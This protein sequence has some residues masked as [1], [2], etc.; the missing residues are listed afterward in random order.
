MNF[1]L[2]RGAGLARFQTL[3]VFLGGRHS[4]EDISAPGSCRAGALARRLALRNPSI[5]A[6]SFFNSS[7]TLGEVRASS[8]FLVG[9]R[10]ARTPVLHFWIECFWQISHFS[11]FPESGKDLRAKSL[12]NLPLICFLPHR[13][14]ITA[15]PICS[16]LRLRNY[17]LADGL[18]RRPHDRSRPAGLCRLAER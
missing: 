10:R 6:V 4:F 13:L 9:R 15:C 18:E 8:G 2:P 17:G 3:P 11:P 16:S 7:G 14:Q 5:W 12:S 1:L